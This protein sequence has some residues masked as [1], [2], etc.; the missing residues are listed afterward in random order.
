MSD[1]TDRKSRLRQRQPRQPQMDAGSGKTGYGVLTGIGVGPGDPGLVTVRA[2]EAIRDAAAVAYPVH[3]PGASS[4]A[5]ETVNGY[6]GDSAIR[7]PLLMPMTRDPDRLR[8][9]HEAAAQILEATAANGTDIVYL[10]LGDPLFYS[11]FGYLAER[12]PGPVDV[13][14]G[15]SSISAMAAAAGLPLAAGDTATVVVTGKDHRGVESA[16]EIKASLVVI[17]PRS[18]S[19]ET[20]DLLEESGALGRAVAALELGGAGE[21]II[22]NLDRSAVA[23]LPYFSIIWIRPGGGAADA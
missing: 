5:L 10:S 16:L 6:L 23:G 17:K 14:S 2:V 9:A 21:Q 7:L 1:Y 4:R 15:V 22:E 20:L 19:P 18:L 11:T 12:F 3:K 13:I 8:E